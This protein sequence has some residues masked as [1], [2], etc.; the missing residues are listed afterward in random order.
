M[1]RKASKLMIEDVLHA[2]PLYLIPAFS[3]VLI[4]DAV[5][6]IEKWENFY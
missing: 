5:R 6:G 2:W 1:R 3:P 4:S